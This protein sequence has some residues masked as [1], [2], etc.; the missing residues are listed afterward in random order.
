MNLK[1]TIQKLNFDYI[2]SDITEKNFP[3][4]KVQAIKLGK[5]VSSEEALRL[6]DEKGLR[7]ATLYELLDYAKE[8]NGEDYVVA[9]GSVWQDSSGR[10]RVPFL[11]RYYGGR[12]LNLSS[13][14]GG[15]LDF[16]F[17]AAVS[18][19]VEISDTKKSDFCS[20]E[21]LELLKKEFSE[22]KDKVTKVLKL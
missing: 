3:K 19:Y 4:P 16:W 20:L 10:R 13:W 7:P 14:D 15:W 6:L 21:S 22:F 1:E 18:K 12:V 5:E 2:N 8:W 11:G 17:F 9:L